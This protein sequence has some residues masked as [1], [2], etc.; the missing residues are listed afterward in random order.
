MRG[1]AKEKGG[2]AKRN[3]FT[4]STMHLT[5]SAHETQNNGEGD[6]V[7]WACLWNR[8]VFARGQF[9]NT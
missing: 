9:I 3:G 8:K 5:T 4:R 7:G 2:A 6:S 1:P